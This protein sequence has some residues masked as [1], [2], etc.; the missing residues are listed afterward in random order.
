M[1][2]TIRNTS[3]PVLILCCLL[4][5]PLLAIVGVI[6]VFAGSELWWI[7][8]LVLFLMFIFAPEQHVTDYNLWE[9][10]FAGLIMGGSLAMLTTCS[11][12]NFVYPELWLLRSPGFSIACTVAFAIA[13]AFFLAVDLRRKI[14][15][16][17]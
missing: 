5:I 12:V 17:Q 6:L 10:L 9:A 8:S 2:R 13:A 11:V 4:S 15:Q 7:P 1:A 14:K 3:V 16:G